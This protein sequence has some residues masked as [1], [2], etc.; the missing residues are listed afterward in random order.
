MYRGVCVP[1]HVSRKEGQTKKQKERPKNRISHSICLTRTSHTFS[2]VHIFS[3]FQVHSCMNS[4]VLHENVNTVEWDEE[5]ERINYIQ[6][7][8]E[9]IHA[10]YTYP[11]KTEQ[12]LEEEWLP[13]GQD[14]KEDENISRRY[15]KKQRK[16]RIHREPNRY[17][18]LVDVDEAVEISMI[19][20]EYEAKHI[21]YDEAVRAVREVYR[22]QGEKRWNP[23]VRLAFAHKLQNMYRYCYKYEITLTLEEEKLLGVPWFFK[24]LV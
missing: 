24:H 16:P 15:Y 1:V 13:E 9:A 3:C 12:N 23:I 5:Q 19:Q 22:R 8:V 20:D 7:A 2:P 14:V 21:N 10:G 17:Q 18:K 4:F 11:L 6:N